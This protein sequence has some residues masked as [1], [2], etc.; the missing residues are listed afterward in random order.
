[1]YIY[2]SYG[3]IVCYRTG[4]LSNKAHLFGVIKGFTNTDMMLFQSA[5]DKLYGSQMHEHMCLK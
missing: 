2:I 5:L 1:M 4:D 3:Q